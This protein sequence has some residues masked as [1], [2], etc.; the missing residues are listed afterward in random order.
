MYDF[1]GSDVLM[2]TAAQLMALLP[3][4]KQLT[5]ILLLLVAWPGGGAER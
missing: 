4:A 3:R 2:H 1:Q 5:N